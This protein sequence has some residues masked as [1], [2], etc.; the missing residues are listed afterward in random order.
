LRKNADRDE[1]ELENAKKRANT[2]E[3]AQRKPLSKRSR[4]RSGRFHA[5]Y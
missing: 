1:D 2:K 3:H 4:N 5:T